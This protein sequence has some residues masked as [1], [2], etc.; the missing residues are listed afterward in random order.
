MM[1]EAVWRSPP[2]RTV[3]RRRSRVEQMGPKHPFLCAGSATGDGHRRRPPATATGD[4]HRR[5][6]PQ[7]RADDL[8]HIERPGRGVPRG[9]ERL[10]RG[11]SRRV[12]GS[13]G[14]RAAA[15]PP[16][17]AQRF[18]ERVRERSGR[19]V[20]RTWRGE[21]ATRNE[22]AAERVER[23]TTEPLGHRAA[24]TGPR[25]TASLPDDHGAGTGDRAPRPPTGRRRQ[26]RP[27]ATSGGSYA[28]QAD[29]WRAVAGGRTRPRWRV[30]TRRAHGSHRRPEPAPPAPPTPLCPTCPDPAAR[31]PDAA[32]AGR[33]ERPPDPGSVG[34]CRPAA[35]GHRAWS[36]PLVPCSRG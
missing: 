10:G 21:A 28:H 6:G 2:T 35:P 4:G 1:S 14:P 24:G 31:G 36:S 32:A 33:L 15:Q 17:A 11:M 18:N 30:S 9:V 25:V 13:G 20:T 22:R 34:G 16:R 19:P 7:S 23:R 29:R 5:L 8:G 26:E 12:E 27:P 3:V